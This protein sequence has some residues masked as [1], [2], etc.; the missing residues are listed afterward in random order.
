[1]YE[2]SK[3]KKTEKQRKALKERRGKDGLALDGKY[4]YRICDGN[5]S[6]SYE[7]I[8]EFQL[9]LIFILKPFQFG[10]ISEYQIRS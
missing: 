5:I 8:L 4:L 3:K 2:P 6:N 10:F 9:N 1:M 7:Y